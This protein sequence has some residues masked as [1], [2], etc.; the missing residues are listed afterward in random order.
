MNGVAPTRAVG[1]DGI[2]FL[3]VS[4]D[5]DLPSFLVVNSQGRYLVDSERLRRR[6]TERDPLVRQLQLLAPDALEQQIRS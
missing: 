5:P 4:P 2:W 3:Q 1:D 6:L